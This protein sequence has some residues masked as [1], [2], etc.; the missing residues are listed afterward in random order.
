[1]VPGDSSSIFIG[2][3]LIGLFILYLVRENNAVKRRSD[4]LHTL[5]KEKGYSYEAYDKSNERLHRKYKLFHYFNVGRLRHSSNIIRFTGEDCSIT[6]F[7]YTCTTGVGKN[8]HP[9][10][11]TNIIIYQES[12]HYPHFFI[13]RETPGFDR[14]DKMFG[15]QDITIDANDDFSKSFVLQGQD[16]E[17]IR[18]F[19]SDSGRCTPFLIFAKRNITFEA[20]GSYFR[21]QHLGRM[22]VEEFSRT[23]QQVQELVALLPT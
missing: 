9:R 2:V 15:M 5:A 3:L 6:V 7:D 11:S 21:Y 4:A 8:S 17:K 1:M 19:F 18:R 23:V 14:I 22:T 20:K 13:R 12:R 16:E 10:T